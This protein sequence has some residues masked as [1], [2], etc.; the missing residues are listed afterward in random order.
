M[1][2]YFHTSVF[3]LL[4]KLHLLVIGACVDVYGEILVMLAEIQMLGILFV[5]LFVCFVA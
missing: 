4:L 5:C 3:K 1:L 2:P